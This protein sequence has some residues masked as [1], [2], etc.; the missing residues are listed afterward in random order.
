MGEAPVRISFIHALIIFFPLSLPPSLPA[1]LPLL[2]LKQRPLF[3]ARAL[4]NRCPAHEVLVQ[5]PNHTQAN[6]GEEEGRGRGER[7]PVMRRRKEGGREGG[8]VVNKGVRKFSL[9]PSLPPSLLTGRIV[10]CALG[11]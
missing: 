2:K 9:P 8:R 4:Q 1:P 3:L 10:V 11:L 7:P 6:D 5:S